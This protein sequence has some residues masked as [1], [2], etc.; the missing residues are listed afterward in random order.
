[1]GE[2]MREGEN[3]RGA[4]RAIETTRAIGVVETMRAIE[5]MREGESMREDQRGRG[6][7]MGV[8]E[9]MRGGRSHERERLCDRIRDEPW[10]S[11]RPCQ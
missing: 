1:M 8:I 2:T 10:E 4:M 9:T 5:A 7:D 11:S 6:H 3:Q